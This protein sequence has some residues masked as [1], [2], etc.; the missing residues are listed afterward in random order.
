MPGG[1]SRLG[2]S[3]GNAGVR[4]VLYL[5][6]SPSGSPTAHSGFSTPK[7]KS[8]SVLY[9]WRFARRFTRQRLIRI[10]RRRR[11]AGIPMAGI[12]RGDAVAGQ[13]YTHRSPAHTA[14]SATEAPCR[15][16][17]TNNAADELLDNWGLGDRVYAARKTLHENVCGHQRV[18][19]L[20]TEPALDADPPEDS[21]ARSV[22]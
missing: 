13:S 5:S 10:T 12:W 19:E 15:C 4:A 9:R 11:V 16:T 22:R 18:D 1:W 7:I 21:S 14:G 3:A 20:V 6:W 8:K 2:F 17:K